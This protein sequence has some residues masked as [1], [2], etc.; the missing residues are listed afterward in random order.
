ME[1]KEEASSW[2]LREGSK[3]VKRHRRAF[4][5]QRTVWGTTARRR[6]QLPFVSGDRHQELV[7]PE[8]R[9]C[10]WKKQETVWSAPSYSASPVVDLRPMNVMSWEHYPRAAPH[11]VSGKGGTWRQ[12]QHPRWLLQHPGT[13]NETWTAVALRARG[14]NESRETP[15]GRSSR[16]GSH[17]I[18]EKRARNKYWSPRTIS[19]AAQLGWKNLKHPEI[20]LRHLHTAGRCVGHNLQRAYSV[21]T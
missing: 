19:E 13:S 21:G 3:L 10:V 2:D 14:R 15:K 1:Q 5:A 9:V 4:L 12:R 17:G 7:K 8:L 20:H 11:G 6:Q 18:R 16:R